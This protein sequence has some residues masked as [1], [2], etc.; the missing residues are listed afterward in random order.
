ME[1]IARA[2]SRFN[3]VNFETPKAIIVFCGMGVVLSL[4]LSLMCAAAGLD[5]GSGC[6]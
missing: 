4:A 5:P 6:F 3:D 1:R 2:G